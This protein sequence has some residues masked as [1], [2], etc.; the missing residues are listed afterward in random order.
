VDKEALFAPRLGDPADV[1]IP[2]V[3]TVT[4]RGLSRAEALHVQAASDATEK[5]RRIIAQ[6]LVD[7]ELLI[8][9]LKHRSDDRPCEKCADAG[10]WQQ[11]SLADEIEPVTDRI[12]EL[13][14]MK[15]GADKGAYKS[16]PD[17][18]GAGVRV[19]PGDPAGDDGGPAAPGDVQ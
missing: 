18:S 13:S 16:L 8:P 5:D 2:G 4:V 17:G 14:G 6:G 15:D 7:P 10:R 19:L 12:A 9:G 3:G 1:E 11:A